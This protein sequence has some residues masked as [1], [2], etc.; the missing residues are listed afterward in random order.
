MSAS[1]E[2]S[3]INNFK[4]L[5]EL[6]SLNVKDKT[7]CKDCI[8]FAMCITKYAQNCFTIEGLTHQIPTFYTVKCGILIRE[9]L[10]IT[11]KIDLSSLFL[12]PYEINSLL[13]YKIFKDDLD[14]NEKL[15]N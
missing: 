8:S 7:S 15:N 2:Y 3:K 1:R 10:L 11:A 14:N 4:F 9:M 5:R 13:V 6:I 12:S